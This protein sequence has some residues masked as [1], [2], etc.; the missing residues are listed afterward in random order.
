[1]AFTSVAVPARKNVQAPTVAYSYKSTSF[2]I[3]AQ[4]SLDDCA[5]VVFEIDGVRERYRLNRFHTVV[6]AEILYNKMM[7]HPN[8]H[9]DTSLPIFQ[10]K[11]DCE[12]LYFVAIPQRGVTIEEFLK[13]SSNRD[14]LF[15]CLHSGRKIRFSD[16]YKNLMKEVVKIVI[17]LKDIGKQNKVIT[18]SSKLLAFI[19]MIY[20]KTKTD[21]DAVDLS[22]HEITEVKA[23]LDCANGHNIDKTVFQLPLFWN[24]NKRCEFTSKVY[25]YLESHWW[26]SVAMGAFPFLW[27]NI[28]WRMGP[29]LFLRL[30]MFSEEYCFT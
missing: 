22:I 13:T 30:D 28:W 14:S 24:A 12:E 19:K 18:P 25:M 29:L 7:E 27:F 5:L 17:H 15:D 16:Q 4:E 2:L 10:V 1:M 9:I 21:I 11:K 23:A 20:T 6:E 26:S 8:S 3:E